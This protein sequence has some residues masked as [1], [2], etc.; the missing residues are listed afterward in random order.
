VRVLKGE[1]PI[2]FEKTVDEKA[3]IMDLAGWEGIHV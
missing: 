1:Q 2:N 3:E